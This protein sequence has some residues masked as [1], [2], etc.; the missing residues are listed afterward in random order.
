MP[1]EIDIKFAFG[2]MIAMSLIGHIYAEQ[3]EKLTGVTIE[4]A[5]EINYRRI[6]DK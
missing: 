1:N 5:D 2:Y 3:F 6:M 4:E